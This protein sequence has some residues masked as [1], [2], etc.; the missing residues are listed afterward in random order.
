VSGPYQKV[1][2]HFLQPGSDGDGSV[3][4]WIGLNGTT[5]GGNDRLIQAGMDTNGHPFWELFCSGGAADGCNAAVNGPVSASA[6]ADISV[7]VSFNPATRMSYY[8]VA[9]NGNQVVNIQYQMIAG[10]HSG[11]EAEFMT[12]RPAGAT[13]PIPLVGNVSF[14]GSRT[15]TVWNSDT[16]VPFGLQNYSSDEMEDVANNDFYTPPCAN[17]VH[18]LMYPSNITS[19][20]FTNN[21]CRT[22]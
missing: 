15:Y 9:V 14:S 2:G 6:G 1:V 21:F 16:S 8:A 22:P 5:Q 20:G 4:N 7:S 19:G 3:S 11:D 17:N 10:S 12:E 18:I 13:T